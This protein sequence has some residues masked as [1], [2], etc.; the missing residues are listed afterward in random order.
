MFNSGEQSTSTKVRA[1]SYSHLDVARKTSDRVESLKTSSLRQEAR[2]LTEEHLMSMEPKNKNKFGSIVPMLG[3]VVDLPTSRSTESVAV[4]VAS[5]GGLV[6]GGCHNT[7]DEE[8]RWFVCGS[9]LEG[10][11]RFS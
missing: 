2:T 7:H 5:P 8:A 3:L 10:A 9:Q 1:K 4:D 6:I 11:L